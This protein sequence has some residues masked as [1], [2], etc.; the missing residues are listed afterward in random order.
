MRV[1]VTG[2]SGFI[3]QAVVA[4]LLAHGHQVVGLA[5]SDEA[6]RRLAALGAGSHHGSLDDPASL[7]AGAAAADGVVHLAFSSDLTRPQENL[8]TER[9][10]VTAMAEAL[11]G[12][13]RPL[14]VT[15]GTMVLAPGHLG[16]EDEPGLAEGPGAPR[17]AGERVVLDFALRGVRGSIVRLAPCVH[18]RERL[19]FAGVLEGI[20]RDKG[21]S[22]Y[23]GEGANRWPAI[24]RDDAA[25]L[26]R[27]ALEDAP[28]GTVLHGAGEQ[29][30]ALKEIATAIGE[31]LGVPVE[32]VADEQ[33]FAHFGWIA[34]PMTLDM[35][36]SSELTRE[37]FDWEPTHPGLLDDLRG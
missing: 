23:L 31:K 21:V 15:S 5:R 35:P 6:A 34:Q 9:A 8:A 16:T 19:G 24:H 30:V 20:A 14:V 36:S 7:A 29:G 25:V 10:A 1:F 18:S 17:V 22:G 32:R 4:E 2:G 26:F 37:R 28:A 11:A 27:A 13:D 3:G 12:S 33:A